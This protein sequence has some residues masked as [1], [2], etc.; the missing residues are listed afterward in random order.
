MHRAVLGMA[1]GLEP[2]QARPGQNAG[3]T[4]ALAWPA[5]LKSQPEAAASRWRI[6]LVDLLGHI[7]F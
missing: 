6:Q 3:F 5:F 1:S 2:G 4:V 7:T